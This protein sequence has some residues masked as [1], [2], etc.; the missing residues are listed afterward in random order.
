VDGHVITELEVADAS[1]LYAKGWKAPVRKAVKAAD[2]ITDIYTVYYAPG[3]TLPG[4]K[5]PVIDAAYG[6]P[7]VIVAPRNFIEAYSN[8]LPLGQS[9]LAR[10]GFAVVTIDGRGT[11][12]RSNSFRDKGFPEFTQVGIDD[13]IAAIKN[14]AKE[15]FEMDINRVGVFGW[16]WGGTFS[17][18]A[19]LSRSEFYKVAVSGAG[20]YDYA[21]MMRGVQSIDNYIG[22]PV[23]SNGSNYRTSV[24][25]RPL[26]WDKLDITRMA[27]GLEG[28]LLL[29][30]G[31]MDENVPQNQT[32]QLINSLMK[33]NK[34]YDLLYLPNRNHNSGQEG[35]VIQRKMD[36]FVEHLL[37]V[38][39]PRDVTISHNFLETP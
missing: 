12:L 4:G 16:S 5:H 27:G 20:V 18:Q 36:Y 6:G 19:I 24:R 22:V 7:Q 13:H 30:Y 10:L 39:S 23:Y 11:P 34:P 26:N 14:L 33:A 2:D 31:D 15:N 8:T 28:Q 35:Y 38:T 9:A 37:E 1:R 29:I 17:A 25:D 3:K 32:F 21:G